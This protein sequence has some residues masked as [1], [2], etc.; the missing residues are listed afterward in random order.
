MEWYI[1]NQRTATK[2]FISLG[3]NRELFGKCLAANL[4]IRP[5]EP[6]PNSAAAAVHLAVV[7]TTTTTAAKI[8]AKCVTKLPITYKARK[9][10]C[11]RAHLDDGSGA[12]VCVCVKPGVCERDGLKQKAR[13]CRQLNSIVNSIL[14][15][16]T[17]RPA[18]ATPTF[19]LSNE[20]FT[21]RVA[22]P[23]ELLSLSLSHSHSTHS[24]A[25][26]FCLHLRAYVC[27][28]VAKA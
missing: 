13:Y 26:C 2:S 6:A 15:L 17:R 18:M 25:V 10:V 1:K 12:C 20:A 27:M 3:A 21:E 5:L 24:R 14:K 9:A 11:A 19:L 8:K 23:C 4:C 16:A 7:T 28:C 22:T